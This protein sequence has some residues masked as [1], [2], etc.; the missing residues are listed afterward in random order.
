MPRILVCVALLA[1][2]GTDTDLRPETAD[3]IIEAI[4]APSCGR[5]ACHSSETAA[6]NLAFD[7]IAAG[8]AALSSGSGK[9]GQKLVVAG[10]P[11][12]SEIVTILSDS[13]GPMPPDS[14][15]PEADI[16]LITRWVADGA[17][18]LP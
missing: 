17:A 18:G 10:S 4:L 2:C 16:E 3:Y 7:T 11:S 12:Q 15:L 5:A 13:N 1:A 14:P 8:M 9:R 6:H